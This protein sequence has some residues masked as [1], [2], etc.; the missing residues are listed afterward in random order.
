MSDMSESDRSYNLLEC[1]KLAQRAEGENP[2][3]M[4]K[5]LL[6]A[7]E[8][9]DFVSG[10]NSVDEPD[11]PEESMNSWFARAFTELHPEVTED[12]PEESA[13]EPTFDFG[14]T[15]DA[16]KDG[17]QVARNGWNGKDMF[18]FLVDGSTFQVNRAPLSGIYPEGTEINYHAHID[19]RTAD[20]I[21]VPW[22]A[23]QTDLLAEDWCVV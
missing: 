18:L 12:E 9:A 16:I 5:V 19:I 22:L 7:E 21:I 20:G 14:T 10:E 13:A 8:Y 2:S 11:E 15:L 23:S 6:R 1:L 17:E 4:E 3:V